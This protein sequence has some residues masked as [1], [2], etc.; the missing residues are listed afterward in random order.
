MTISVI[1][2]N[3]Y[4]I[5]T[6]SIKVRGIQGQKSEAEHFSLLIK[7]AFISGT[8]IYIHQWNTYF[9]FADLKKLRSSRFRPSTGSSAVALVASIS[10]STMVR[11]P[12]SVKYKRFG[13][14]TH[15]RH[16]R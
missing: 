10:F 7:L 3:V 16:L 12:R 1:N 6:Y 13:S 8:E 5:E 11:A 15:T 2:T 14:N 9:P 4:N